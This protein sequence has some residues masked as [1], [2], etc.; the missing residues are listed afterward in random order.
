MPK[1]VGL[2]LAAAKKKLNAAGCAHAT[3][4]HRKGGRKQRGKVVAQSKKAKSKISATTKVTV[5]V[6]S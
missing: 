4:K 3:V 1:L 6:G 2:S 5:I